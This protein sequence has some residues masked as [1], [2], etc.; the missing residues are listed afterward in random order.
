MTPNNDVIALENVE[1]VWDIK[2][3]MKFQ[4]TTTALSFYVCNI[5]LFKEMNLFFVWPIDELKKKTCQFF[6]VFWE[7]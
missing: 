3:F 5:K 1:S 6:K 4:E 7:K 2:P